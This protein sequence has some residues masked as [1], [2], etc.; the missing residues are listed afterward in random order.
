VNVVVI[1]DR[2]SCDDLL[3]RV[4]AIARVP[5]VMFQVREKD[6]DGGA[7]LALTRAVI[8]AA[9]GAPVWVNDR[10]DVARLAG[11]SGV[12]LPE[13][14]LPID[15]VR[16]LAPEL[17]IGCSRHDADAARAAADAGADLVQLGPCFATPGKPTLG[18]APLATKIAARLV[19][20]G[21]ITG[22][23]EARA[24]RRAGADAVAVIRAA[25]TSVDPA[26]A[27]AA[28][29]DAVSTSSAAS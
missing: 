17:A 29:A 21:G 22:P 25:W 16:A 13:A 2:R 6:L 4:A 15:V 27:I 26:S 18:L 19:A 23:D 24:A 14:G 12:H 11:A 7:L 5:G 20:V 9:N 28:I 3:E 1:T 10:V 8:A